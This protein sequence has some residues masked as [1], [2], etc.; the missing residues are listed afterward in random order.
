MLVS[1]SGLDEVR[2]CLVFCVLDF[3]RVG[4]KGDLAKGLFDLR[5]RGKEGS[6]QDVIVI[7]YYTVLIIIKSIQAIT[8]KA[9]LAKET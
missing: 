1:L 2:D 6:A 4:A 8:G 5:E 7:H 3:V 9:S